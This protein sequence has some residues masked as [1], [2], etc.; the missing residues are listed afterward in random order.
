MKM[1]DPKDARKLG[2]WLMAKYIQ[3]RQETATTAQ[4]AAPVDVAVAPA[5]VTTAP[6]DVPTAPVYV[7]VTPANTVGAPVV[8]Q[9]VPAQ[10]FSPAATS[11]PVAA[12]I[13][14]FE[15]TTA[16]APVEVSTAEPTTS[17]PK[18]DTARQGT[19]QIPALTHEQ[20]VHIAM[21]NAQLSPE[22]QAT[23]EQV[24]RRM[25]MANV[26]RWLVALGELS[27]DDATARVR[28]AIA[29]RNQRRTKMT[30]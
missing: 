13:V 20:L 9:V 12:E 5:N 28:Q 25:G 17:E 16:L 30:R 21:I 8:V 3:F 11:A 27:V 19:G 23:A 4:P 1:I 6:A 18:E 29:E 7:A 14:P 2:S 26:Q 10:V 15:V 22:E 24:M